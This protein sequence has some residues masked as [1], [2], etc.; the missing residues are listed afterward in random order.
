MIA[1]CHRRSPRGSSSRGTLIWV[2]ALIIVAAIV[3]HEF[4]SGSH[5]IHYREVLERHGEPVAKTAVPRPG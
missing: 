2:L 3:R 4:F 1:A 5:G